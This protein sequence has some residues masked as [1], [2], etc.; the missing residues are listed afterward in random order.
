MSHYI[1]SMR[2]CIMRARGYA[3]NGYEMRVT[4]SFCAKEFARLKKTENPLEAGMPQIKNVVLD[5]CGIRGIPSYARPSMSQA[6]PRASKGLVTLEVCFDVSEYNAIRLGVK[7]DGHYISLSIDL[8][9]TLDSTRFDGH[10][11]AK[12]SLASHFGN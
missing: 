10:L 1:K 12:S 9:T 4:V 5:A 3:S 2:G 8:Q 11:L 7:A 6:F